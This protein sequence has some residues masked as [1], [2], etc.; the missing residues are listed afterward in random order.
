MHNGLPPEIAVCDMEEIE[1]M[2]FT[3]NATNFP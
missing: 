2:Q 3:Y 1:A